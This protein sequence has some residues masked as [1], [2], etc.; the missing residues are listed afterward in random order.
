MAE[1]NTAP[2][3]SQLKRTNKACDK[4]YEHCREDKAQ[5]DQL[6]EYV[7]PNR[8]PAGTSTASRAARN[9]KIFDATATKAAYRFAGRMQQDVTPAFQ[10]FFELKVGPYLEIEGD[11]KK[12]IEQDLETITKKVTA[13]LE[14]AQ[15]SVASGEMYLDL[16][17][18]TGAMLILPH[19]REVC[20]FV[21]VPVG[22]IALRENGA[23]V[24][25]G[26]YWKR[27]YSAG[28]IPHLWPKDRT[29]LSKRL[30]DLAEQEPDT[31]VTIVQASEFNEETGQWQFLAYCPDKM[32]E[33]ALYHTTE[34]TCPWLTPRFY[35][36]PGRAMG[37]GPGLIGLPTAKTLNKVVELTIKAAAFAILGL[38]IHKNDRVFNPKT[39]KM[40]PGA[41][42]AV[43][44]TGGT[45]GASVQRLEVPGR[46]D[47]SNLILNELRDAVKSVML[48][49]TLPPDSG[50][51][52]S[53]TEIVERMKRLSADLSGAYSR[54]VLEII[55]PLIQRII[56]ILWSRN[57]IKANIN[58]DQLLF[59]VEVVSPIARLQQAQDV[60]N[61]VE[62]LQ[63]VMSIG[64]MEMLML[65]AK[66]EDI[67]SDIGRKLGVPEKFVRSEAEKKSIQKLVAQL[68]ANAQM[69][70]QQAKQSPAGA[71]APGDLVQA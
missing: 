16:F 34:R 6:Y 9:E 21:T 36:V 31:S 35:K 65:T 48:D 63:I 38:W 70:A 23:G 69:Q 60:S 57:L 11:E 42:W 7:L 45:M 15:F 41:M 5:L 66:V 59:K 37:T 18:G 30:K 12:A 58:I 67:F 40:R 49:D 25:N 46:F 39:A 53:A 24:V 44:A 50:A 33:G 47:I 1:K 56:D 52:R 20:R 29:N 13:V 8:A 19:E 62:W 32:D 61:L 4:A 43:G 17:G 28:D 3:E 10:R 55:R 22:E 64:G 2:T 68:I 27:A 14:G 71:P 26:I 54:L 51:V